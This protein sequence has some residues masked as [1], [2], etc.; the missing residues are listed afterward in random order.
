MY[1]GKNKTKQNR[2]SAKSL[3]GGPSNAPSKEKRCPYRK[4]VLVP[5]TKGEKH[6]KQG[7]Q[8]AVPNVAEIGIELG[9][10][11]LAGF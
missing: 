4:M 1:W 10:Q 3:H 6:F 8:L 7:V 9:M 5:G 2:G 11:T